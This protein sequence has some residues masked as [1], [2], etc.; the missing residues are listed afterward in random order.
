MTKR[1]L[2]LTFENALTKVAGVIGWPEV[3]RI[4][5]QVERTCRNWSEPDTTAAIS[6]DAARKLDVAFL[7]AGGEG[8]PFLI[9]YA[10]RI[11]ADSL[12][13]TPGREQLLDSIGKAARE[14]GEAVCATLSAALPNASPAHFAIAERELEES[15]C[16]LTHSLAALRIRSKAAAAGDLLRDQA[17]AA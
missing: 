4:C 5:G 6:L 11:E 16:A 17:E 12:A 7:A 14:S 13:A 1:R 10:T 3:A 9:C 2:P 15:I 8:A